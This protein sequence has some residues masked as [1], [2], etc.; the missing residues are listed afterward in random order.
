MMLLGALE[1]TDIA[2]P[3]TEQ[4][5]TFDFIVSYAD[6]QI[7]GAVWLPRAASPKAIVLVGHGGSQHKRSGSV[8]RLAE[9]LT[10]GSEFAVAAIDGPIHGSR[11]AGV[12]LSPKAQQRKFLELWEI[13]D[14]QVSAMVDD[15]RAVLS[16]LFLV[17]EIGE[18]P[19][20]YSGI[21]MGTA[22]GLPLLASEPRIEA[23][24]VGMWSADYPS[25]NRLVSAAKQVTCATLFIAR[26]EDEL[27]SSG[28]MRDLF[29]SIATDDKRMLILPGKH[30]ETQ[31]QF[32]QT[33]FFLT[34]RLSGDSGKLFRSA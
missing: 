13:G 30:V 22:Y 12:S 29:D 24:V 21:S 26:Y 23:A 3:A 15:W 1:R 31:E 17:S 16:S 34:E 19:V 32:V 11:N 10:R 5:T 2:L 33:A 7:P 28:G 27:F 9:L 8:L 25:S 14:G 6:R 18:I 20:G 4:M